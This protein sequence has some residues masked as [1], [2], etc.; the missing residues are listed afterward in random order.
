MASLVVSC[1]HVILLPHLCHVHIHV[2][3]CV[4]VCVRA[5]VCVCTRVRGCGDERIH[6][7]TCA[8]LFLCLCVLVSSNIGSHTCMSADFP[9][10]FLTSWSGPKKLSAA[11]HGHAS[12][13]PSAVA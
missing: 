5:W 4:C 13:T 10:F 3:V 9:R 6:A 1:I 12:G 2:C 11:T 8:C 7:C